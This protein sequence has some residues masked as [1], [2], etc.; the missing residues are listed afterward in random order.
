MA[1]FVFNIAKGRVAELHEIVRGGVVA[2]ARLYLVPVTVTTATDAALMDCATLTAVLATTGI[3]EVTTNGWSRKTIV[4]GSLSAP[5]VDNALDKLEVDMA[6]VTWAAPAAAGPPTDL[7]LCYSA[8]AQPGG[9][10]AAMLPLCQ[11]DFPVTPD[12]TSD[13]VAQVNASGYF[14]AT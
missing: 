5:A 3:S 7:I 2:A 6:D 8:V 1:D 13:V 4:A 12:G 9:G 11:Y 14:R 10:N